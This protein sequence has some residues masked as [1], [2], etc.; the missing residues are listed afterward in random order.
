MRVN[1]ALSMLPLFTPQP[2]IPA[3]G[4]SQTIIKQDQEKCE[5]LDGLWVPKIHPWR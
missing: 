4:V 3:T 1:Q 5:T 2:H